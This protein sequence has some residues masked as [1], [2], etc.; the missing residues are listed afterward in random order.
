MQLKGKWKIIGII[1]FVLLLTT[2]VTASPG[3]E[4]RTHYGMLSLLP[5]IVAILLAIMTKEVIPSL[6]IGLWVAGTM[7]ASGNPIVGFGKSVETLWENLGDPW[8]ARIV[9]TSLTMGGLVG[10][11]RVGGGI[12]AVVQWITSRIK[13]VKGAM[14]ATQ[15]AGFIIFFEDYVNTLVVGTTMGPINDKHKISKEKFSYIVDSTAAPIACI[16][17]ISSWIAYMVGQIGSQFTQLDI[18]Y[19]PYLAYFR[20]IPFIIYNIIALVLLTYVILSQRDMGPMLAAERRAR[21][22]GK[23]LRDG[24]Q[25][26]INMNKDEL[27]PEENCPKR[28]INFILPLA[29]LIGLIL[30]LMLTTGGWP[31]ESFATAMGESSSSVALV[32][33]SFGALVITILFYWAQGVAPLK[34]LFSGYIQGMQS[35]FVG[36]LILIFAWGIGAA[37]KQV[38]T[39]AF[40]VG[41]TEGILSPQFIP[42]ITFIAGALIS[43]ST[44][45]SYGTMAVLMPIVAPLVHGTSISA[46][47]DPMTFMIPTIGAVFA[48]A[49]FGDHCSP[50]SDTTIMSSMFTGADH[51]D[52]V[53]S[54]A[55]YALLAA[56]GALGGYIGV[57]IGLPAV[58]NLIIAAGITLGL[59][60]VLSKPIMEHGQEQLKSNINS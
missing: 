29:S 7:L 27:K 54:Q 8:S 31:K 41:A 53:N 26:L 46:G 1:V 45:T 34:R 10:V 14:I 59:F 36:T 52:H 3:G 22:T 5:P 11:M 16:A 13:T 25:P 17:G 43:F 33:G 57:A 58:V 23:L 44:G 37:I 21:S 48:G 38:G 50:I 39:A 24:A 15:L 12:D 19:S 42:I 32:W 55:P 47:M 20:S 49:V 56:V 9:L 2:I 28:L 30:V 40:I 60:R 51:I 35:I 6:F 4:A 18:S